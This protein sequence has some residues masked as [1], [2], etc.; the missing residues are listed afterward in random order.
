[1]S[2]V[3]RR[4]V[5]S[6]LHR[7]LELMATV[8]RWKRASLTDRWLA[9]LVRDEDGELEWASRRE[10]EDDVHDITGVLGNR[11]RDHLREQSSI[12]PFP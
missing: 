11:G 6:E 12:R 9:Y 3:L 10:G 4:H 8:S 2:E 1:M 5:K 7:E